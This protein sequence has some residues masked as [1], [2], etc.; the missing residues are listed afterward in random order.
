MRREIGFPVGPLL[1]LSGSD[2]SSPILT[3]NGH[4]AAIGGRSLGMLKLPTLSN[5]CEVPMLWRLTQLARV[6]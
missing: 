1:G 5:N 4:I 3:L 2:R 6:W